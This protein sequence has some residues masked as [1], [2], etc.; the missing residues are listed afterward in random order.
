[1]HLG[2]EWSKKVE[3][4]NGA[5]AEI[6]AAYDEIPLIDSS[7]GSKVLK[8]LNAIGRNQKRQVVE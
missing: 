3:L 8:C 7:K 2:F 5:A 4:K 6:R 1:M